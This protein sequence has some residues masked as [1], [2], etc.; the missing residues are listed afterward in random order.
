MARIAVRVLGSLF[1]A[2]AA[3]SASPA[4]AQSACEFYQALTDAT[5]KDPALL[6]DAER[7]KTDT[8]SL[9]A[10]TVTEIVQKVGDP[11]GFDRSRQA[12][13]G[14]RPRPEMSNP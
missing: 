7:I 3:A 8:R 9:S 1:A 13:Q 11:A 12:R 10:A 2:A 14:G 4:V 6:A 5:M